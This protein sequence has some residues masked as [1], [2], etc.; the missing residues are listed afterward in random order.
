[1]AA[2]SELPAKHCEPSGF[3]SCTPSGSLRKSS[4]RIA[5]VPATDDESTLKWVVSVLPA[6]EAHIATVRERT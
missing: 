1:V 2:V 6:I 3:K 4:T 5:S